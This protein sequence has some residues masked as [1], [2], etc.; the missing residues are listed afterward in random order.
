MTKII[1]NLIIP[2]KSK[3]KKIFLNVVVVLRLLHVVDKMVL[4]LVGKSVTNFYKLNRIK[5]L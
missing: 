4:N 3:K 5:Y 1:R 2:K